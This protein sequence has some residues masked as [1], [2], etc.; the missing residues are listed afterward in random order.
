MADQRRTVAF[1]P[2]GE[3]QDAV[4][5]H[6]AAP[7][8]VDTYG[9]K[10]RLRWDAAA[11][12]TAYGQMPYFIEFLKTAGLFD[13]WVADCPLNYRSP[14]APAERDVLGTLL[15]SLLAGHCRY[16]H[17]NSIR[18]DGVNPQLLGMS[19]IVSEDSAR[20]A[21]Q[22][23]DPEA[24]RDWLREHLQRTYEVLLEEPWILDVDSSVKPLYGHQQGAERGYNPRKPG[25]P[26]QVYHS[27]FVAN[28]RLVLEVEV[29]PGNQTA[30]CYAQPG[31]WEFLDALEPG[32]RPALLRGDVGWGSERMMG[33]AEQRA[34]PYLFKLRQSRG[35]KG[36]LK[37]LFHSEEWEPAGGGWQGIRTEL[38]L[39]GWSRRRSVVVL[40][41][42]IRGDLALSRSETAAPQQL[43]L[44]LAEI[45]DHGVLYE[46]A[47]LVTSL[48]EEVATI[49]QH[50]RDRADAENNFDELKNQWSWAGFTT[51]DLK[52]CQILARMGALVYNWWTLFTRLVIPDK[53]AEAITTRP[54][55][56]HGI[57]RRT[58]HGHQTTVTITSLH[59][60][61]SLMKAALQRGSAFLQ[62]VRTT[63][64]QLTR[65]QRWRLILS[66]IYRRFLCG[67]VVGTTSW[68]TDAPSNCRF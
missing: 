47:V 58:R 33:E 28:L 24:C 34:L 18:S 38:M 23:A 64:G 1:H 4:A 68:V 65:A 31:L 3:D 67:R 26:S 46:Y 44:G 11:A 57:A 59:A 48:D 15:L 50:Y 14:N 16:A 39:A 41:R 21:F 63:A 61:A 5:K 54:L 13:D 40:R 52:R 36:L 53:H 45:V 62:W 66:W 55:L 60:R 9:G 56:L 10:V 22:G 27:Y 12:V 42:Q 7:Q 25:R 49:A 35:V 37:R 20:R 32:R 8:A 51:Q 43:S 29:Q 17:I 2:Q 19:K 30:S 6:S